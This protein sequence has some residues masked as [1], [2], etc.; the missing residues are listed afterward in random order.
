MQ[1]YIGICVILCLWLPFSHGASWSASKRN[2]RNAK[3]IASQSRTSKIVIFGYSYFE[4]LT[5]FFIAPAS[6][7]NLGSIAHGNVKMSSTKHGSTAMYS[8]QTGYALQGTSSRTC[9][10]GSWSG[11]EPICKVI[12]SKRV[13]NTFKNGDKGYVLGMK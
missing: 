6:C 10:M 7:A 12:Y 8:C 4:S 9:Q 2:S 1:W 3:P 11:D 5:L 13:D